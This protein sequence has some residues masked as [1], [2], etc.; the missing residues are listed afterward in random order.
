[1]VR[2]HEWLQSCHPHPL[3]SHSSNHLIY[4]R[5]TFIA[6]VNGNRLLSPHKQ[7]LV[8]K[9]RGR[10]EREEQEGNKIGERRGGR[11]YRVE[12][13][14]VGWEGWCAV[15]RDVG[16]RDSIWG[17]R[18]TWVLKGG[19]T[20][21]DER[22]RREKRKEK[23]NLKQQVCLVISQ[24][25]QWPTHKHTRQLKGVPPRKKELTLTTDLTE[26]G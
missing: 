23:E 13:R 3:F 18:N 14:A 7:A 25:S 1:M 11:E 26:K 2:K 21:V 20:R 22:Q 10:M 19:N 8:G 9:C 6:T 4:N 12:R 5:P 15:E 24:E 16:M 17:E